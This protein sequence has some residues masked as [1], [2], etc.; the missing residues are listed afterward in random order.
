MEIQGFTTTLTEDKS[1][2]PAPIPE[3][4]VEQTKNEIMTKVKESPEVRSIVR[5]I[6]IEDV[7]SI[8]TFGKNTSEEV[9]RFADAIL[10]SMQTTKVE[11][12][13]ELLL[14]LNKI[15]DKFD[16]KDFEEKSPGF[17]SKVFSKA[18]NS[19]EAL[20]H[21]YNSM[22][23]EVDKVF[24]TLKQYEAEINT[25]NKH[26]EDMFIRNTEYYEQLGQYIYA[27]QVVLEELKNN[28][29]PAAQAT[30]NQ[31]GNQ[32]D[33]IKVNN[34][35]QV[36][37]IIEQRI[38]DLQLAENVA[39]QSMPT[40]KSIEYGNYNLIRKINSAFVI[41][42]PIFKQCLVQAIMLKRQ[43]V[44]AKAMSA[45]D[46]K[47]NELLLRNAE[48]TALQS[49]MVA[50][51]A[52]GSAVSIETL[53]KSWQ[54]IV[55]GIEETKA[56]QDEMRQKRIDGTKRLEVLKQEFINRGIIR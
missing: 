14:Q 6:N 33:Q 32:L 27:G 50:K 20:F 42:M 24:V 45:L 35:L 18:K 15:M 2:V 38:Y 56:I 52:S 36:Q 54:T 39:V 37:E 30:A 3:F 10:H 47:T 13:G 23:D 17:L 4:N 5:Q 55:R 11:D 53:E 22:G 43:S 25:A 16:I 31:T 8:M 9:S 29:I 44:Q 41:T 12:S 7:S 40:I 1:L 19:V 28:I 34:L 49:K 46:E 21:K 26:L 51:L 48:N